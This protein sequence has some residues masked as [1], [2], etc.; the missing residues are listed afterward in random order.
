MMQYLGFMFL[1]DAFAH[2]IFMWSDF[3]FYGKIPK[4]SDTQKFAVITL[5]VQEDGFTIE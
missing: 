5:K 2:I 3:L 4:I 1:F